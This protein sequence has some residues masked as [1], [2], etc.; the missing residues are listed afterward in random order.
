MEK[1]RLLS[2]GYWRRGGNPLF[3]SDPCDIY[4]PIFYFDLTPLY[5]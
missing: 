2:D 4:N 1:T 3:W 5:K